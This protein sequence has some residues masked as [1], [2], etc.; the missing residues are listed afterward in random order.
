[1]LN[2]HLT[3][4]FQHLKY[5]RNLSPHT[6]RNYASDLDQ[7]KAHLLSIEKR[8]D[9]DVKMSDI[10]AAAREVIEKAG[11]GD[12]F[13][14]SIGHQ[15]GIE[16]HDVTPDG[17]LKPGMVITIEPGVY[18]PNRKIGVRIEDDI[19]ITAKGNQN[20]TAAIPKTVKEIEAAMSI[21]RASR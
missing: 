9:I 1:M 8:E 15:L 12:A 2:D 5:E 7:F 4:F 3:Q 18:L 11:V 19:L 20:L 16:V 6:L 13:I 10:D 21:G 14:H 17:P